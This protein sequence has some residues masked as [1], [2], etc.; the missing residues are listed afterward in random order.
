M[1][2]KIITPNWYISY[3][4]HQKKVIEL[5]FCAKNGELVGWYQKTVFAS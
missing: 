2:K 3:A 5:L 1:F 4:V